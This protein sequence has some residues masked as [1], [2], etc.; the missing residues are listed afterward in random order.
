[1]ASGFLSGVEH[2]AESWVLP[3]TV[4]TVAQPQ[5]PDLV[6]NLQNLGSWTDV[7]SLISGY[8]PF[9]ASYSD[10]ELLLFGFLALVWLLCAIWTLRDAMA[11]SD[12]SFYQFFSV[13]LIV[14]LTPVFGLPLY[15]AFRPLVYKREKGS[16]R[17]ALEQTVVECPHCRGLNSVSH[18][19]CARCGEAL[20]VECRE[21]H[22]KYSGQ[23]AYCPECG[24]PNIE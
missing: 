14:V 12:S 20:C 13:L 10:R 11:R 2:I 4:D 21:C 16:W 9:L 23:F 18:K 19:V 24:A 5:V 17:E 15:L 8:F 7:V 3:S 1:M 6:V 22:S